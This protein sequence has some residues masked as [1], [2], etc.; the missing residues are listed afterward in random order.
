MAEEIR[1]TSNVQYRYTPDLGEVKPGVP[2][3]CGVCQDLMNENRN[4][5]GPRS[6][7]E[8]LCRSGKIY[9]EFLCPNHEE[10][11]H[12]QVV[13]L[14]N[15]LSFEI[16]LA[17]RQVILQE[18]GNILIWRK[19]TINEPELSIILGRIKYR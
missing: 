9:D 14:R 1:L 18:I 11:W 6:Y 16:C 17:H 5:D 10:G 12:K 3:Y 8:S 7:V 15:K 4:V 13:A 19:P 2:V